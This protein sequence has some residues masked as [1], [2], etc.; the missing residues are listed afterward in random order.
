LIFVRDGGL[1]A[2][3][4]RKEKSHLKY[5]VPEAHNN[6]NLGK[7]MKVAVVDTGVGPHQD[8]KVF[9]GQNFTID[10]A[11]TDSICIFLLI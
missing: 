9:N 3:L 5:N 10:G 6:G 1:K 8:L 4:I 2:Q 7:D 11:D